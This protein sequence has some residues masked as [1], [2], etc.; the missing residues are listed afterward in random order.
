VRANV[1]LLRDGS[2]LVPAAQQALEAA[3][4]VVVA[5]GGDGTLNAVAGV[6]ARTGMPF[7]VLPL[8]TLNHFARDAGIPIEL[9]SAIATIC[10]GRLVHVDLGRVNGRV[11]LNNSSVGLYPEVVLKRDQLQQR[12]R[13]GK[14]PAAAWAAMC[15]LRRFPYFDVSLNV[16]GE[17][18]R[19]RTPLVLIGNNGYELDG[20]RVGRRERLDA[21]LLSVHVIDCRRRLG[22]LG[23]AARALVGRLQQARDFETLYATRVE[24]NTGRRHASVSTDGE[25]EHLAMPLA[26][27]IDPG[28]LSIFVPGTT[29]RRVV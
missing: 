8:G 1:H 7:G 14:W 21:G 24:L 20:L 2:E 6:L 5:G 25:V 29:T 11:F 16:D 18:I 27:E 28:A 10:E 23:L 15:V 17:M 19:R 9:P 3:P 13:R 26:Y 12:L 22:L 4:D